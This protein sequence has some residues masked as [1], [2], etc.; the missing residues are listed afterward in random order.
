VPS[1]FLDP[2]PSRPRMPTPVI[3]IDTDAVVE[4]VDQRNEWRRKEDVRR[5]AIII[6]LAGLLVGGGAAWG[7]MASTVAAA[8]SQKVDR[9][10]FTAYVAQSDRRFQIDSIE[11]AMQAATL[12]RIETKLDASN[13]RL[14]RL[15]CERGPSYCQ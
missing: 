8:V 12:Q 2:S 1:S 10:E 11:R 7:T 5:N 13:G 15:I 9:S 14:S 6:A 3:P 4:Q